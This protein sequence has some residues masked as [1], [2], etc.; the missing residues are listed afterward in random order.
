MKRSH[1]EIGFLLLYDWLPALK[2]L[3]LEDAARLMFAMIDRQ[4]NGTPFPA[5]ENDL[6][7]T[8]AAMI[9]PSIKRRLDGSASGKRGAV[10]TNSATACATA[11]ATPPVTGPATPPATPP[12]TGP[13]TPPVTPPV[14]LKQSKAEQS[15]AEQSKAE[16]SKAQQRGGAAREA[17]PPVAV[18]TATSALPEGKGTPPPE[19]ELSSEETDFLEGQGVPPL[20]AK[21]RFARAVAAARAHGVSPA[22]V[23][24]SWWYQDL[25]EGKGGEY[26]KKREESTAATSTF[27]VDDFFAAAVARN[28]G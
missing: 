9:E 14:H 6:A 12:V 5:F 1:I 4:Q 23:I 2:K 13:A 15:K 16:Q 18:I 11:P 17:S 21:A 7:A 24:L 25:V 28:Y 10:K 26:L 19:S 8:F 27:D 20:Y 22:S 3:P